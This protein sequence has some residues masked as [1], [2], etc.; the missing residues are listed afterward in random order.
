MAKQ[1]INNVKLGVFVITGLFLMVLMLYMIG[2]NQNLFTS[3]F[4]LKVR[5]RNVEGLTRGN[6]VRFSGIQSGTVKGIEIVNDTTIEVSMLINDD[7]KDNIRKNSL[8]YIGSEGLMGNKVINIVSNSTLAPV[9]EEGDILHTREQADLN[10][11]LATLSRTNENVS[12]I[13]QDLMETMH[14]IKNSEMLLALLNDT[15][16]LANL[17][18]SLRNINASSVH[19]N[20]SSAFIEGTMKDMNEGRGLLGLLL[21]NRE[22]ELRATE[23]LN[24]LAITSR[25]VYRLVTR[26]D[27]IA[28]ILEIGINNKDGLVYALLR[29]TALARQLN[30]TLDNVEHGTA[31]FNEDM[32]GLKHNFLLKGY[33]KKKARRAK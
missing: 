13:S 33:F 5:F 4:V 31:A 17:H 12:V 9:V 20:N 23:T 1:T 25:H 22:A 7:V 28:A 32:E 15:F 6:N 11:A 24:D 2:R 16:L 8:A 18:S 19:I 10:E 29:D 26:V 3:N 21:A 30:R 27:S 14:K